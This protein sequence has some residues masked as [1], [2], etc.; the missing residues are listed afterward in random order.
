[1]PRAGYILEHKLHAIDRDR[2]AGGSDDARRLRN[3]ALPNAGPLPRPVSTWPR[4]VF[5]LAAVHEHRALPA[6]GGAKG[7]HVFWWLLPESWREYILYFIKTQMFDISLIE[8]LK[9]NKV[10]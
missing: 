5:E 10:V 7:E 6:H 1:M 9:E 3:T 4:A 2:F 8:F